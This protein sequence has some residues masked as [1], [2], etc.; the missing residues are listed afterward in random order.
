MSTVHTARPDT[1]RLDTAAVCH[2]Q[3]APGVAAVPPYG[4]CNT[5]LV[6]LWRCHGGGSVSPVYAH[7]LQQVA[8]S[9]T[10]PAMPGAGLTM[11]SG[12]TPVLIMA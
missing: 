6:A 11:V 1:A 3:V 4:M 8:T 5:L 2:M 10:S 12:A 9:V 7:T